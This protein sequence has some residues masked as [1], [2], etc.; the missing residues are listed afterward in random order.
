MSITMPLKQIEL[1]PKNVVSNSQCKCKDGLRNTQ[2]SIETLVK[3]EGAIKC[4]E[5]EVMREK[6]EECAG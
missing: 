6:P 5:G 4:T 2:A 1:G 3:R